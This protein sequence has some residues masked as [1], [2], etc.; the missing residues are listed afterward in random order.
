VDLNYNIALKV[1]KTSIK[2][3]WLLTGSHNLVSKIEAQ[4]EDGFRYTKILKS[5]AEGGTLNYNSY[6]G[7]YT[8]IVN[9]LEPKP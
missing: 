3:Q 7:H 6:L 9:F 8:K 1:S 5:R 2:L 4:N